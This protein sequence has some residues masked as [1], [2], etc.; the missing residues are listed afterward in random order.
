MSGARIRIDAVRIA[1]SDRAGAAA[2]AGRL[3]AAVRQQL[4]RT[5]PIVA[6]RG[7]TEVPVIRVRVQSRHGVDPDQVGAAVAD[8]IGSAAQRGADR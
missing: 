7:T 8:A 1:G 2:V 4:E 3:E 6:R 5:P